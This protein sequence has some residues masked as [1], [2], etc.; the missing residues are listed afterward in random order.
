[1][2]DSTEQFRQHV[3]AAAG[4]YGRMD[5]GQLT[6]RNSD[7]TADSLDYHVGRAAQI[8][9]DACDDDSDAIWEY[10]DSR[11]GARLA[12]A[13]SRVERRYYGLPA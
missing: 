10:L 8:L 13:W 5:A 3:R 1:M 2:T 12:A 4:I 11:R 9:R 7:A 6:G